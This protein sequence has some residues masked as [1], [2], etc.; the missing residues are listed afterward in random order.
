MFIEVIFTCCAYACAIFCIFTT[1]I[2]WYAAY[3]QLHIETTVFLAVLSQMLSR[4]NMTNYKTVQIFLTIFNGSFKYVILCVINVL[5]M[6]S[7][8]AFAR[9]V[10]LNTEVLTFA[11]LMYAC[12]LLF[13][14]TTF[15]IRAARITETSTKCIHNWRVNWACRKNI[16]R[17]SRSFA[18]KMLDT[19]FQFEITAGNQMVLRRIEILFLLLVIFNNTVT[20]VVL[21]KQI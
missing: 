7:S 21:G 4:P 9:S 12:V 2:K 20:F 3:A 14:L 8:M 15:V 18:S 6:L 5:V 16:T 17:K 10:L 19:I 13:T 1:L 11:L